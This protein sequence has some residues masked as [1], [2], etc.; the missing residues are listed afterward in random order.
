MLPIT[1]TPAA[2]KYFRKL[3]DNKLK[4][5][6]REAIIKIRKNPHIGDPKKGNLKGIYCIDL[7]YNRT[8]YELAYRISQLENG[9]IEMADEKMK[10]KFLAISGI[11][12]S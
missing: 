4:I 9:D 6:Y 11:L 12:N 2:E 7:Y 10:E 3:K 8:N 1:Y 5:L